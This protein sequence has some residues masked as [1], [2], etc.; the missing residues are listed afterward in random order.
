MI[1]HFLWNL[2]TFILALSILITV[3]EY[4]HFVAARFLKVK[5]ERFSIGFGPILWSWRDANDTEYVISAILFGGYVKLFNTQQTITSCNAECNN[6]FEC[7]HIWKKIII[8]ISGPIFNFLFSIVLYVL[9]FMIGVPIYKPIIHSVIPNSI[10][11]Q[12]NIPSGVEIKS[13]NNIPTH[14]WDAVRLEILNT[15]GKKE[16]IISVT[17]INN[18]HIQTYTIHLSHNW[19]NKSINNKDPII[20]LGILPFNTH[21][22][23]ILSEIQSDSA[24]QR[25]GLKVGDKI[26]SLDDQLIH[27]W[28]S[29][30]TIIKNNPGKTFKIMVERNNKVLNFSLTPDKKN[31]ISSEKTEGAIGVSPQIICIPSKHHI[32]HQY[33][34]HLA[35][36]EACEKTWKLIC[37]TTNTLFKLITG[38]I[39]MTHLSGPI[40]IA[41]GAGASAQSGAI[42]YLMFLSLISINLGIIN[43]L[44]FPTLDGGH[45]FFFVIEK[46]K[47]K[48]ISKKTQ[49]FGYIIGSIILTLM[50]C[51]AIFNDISRLW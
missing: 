13:I 3:H 16:I 22:S 50:M 23:L 38:D 10:V 51:L 27:N 19:F 47:G 29:F 11:D 36:L 20:T 34:L 18:T 1:L 14:D 44:P 2:T 30:I 4:G 35:I 12:S 15:I 24:A 37:L 49:S 28:E 21:V 6:S 25:A 7:K 26:I 5:V 33:G 39:K 40:A 45:L 41:Q 8:V 48:S 17:P 43:L 9:V 31:L 46:I 42:Y 32:I